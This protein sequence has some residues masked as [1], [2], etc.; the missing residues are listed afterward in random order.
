[1]NKII[2]ERRLDPWTCLEG[3]DPHED[4]RGKENECY[5][6][7][8]DTPDC[9]R[10]E[11]GRIDHR[12]DEPWDGKHPQMRANAEASELFTLRAMVS[13]N[14]GCQQQVRAKEACTHQLHPKERIDPT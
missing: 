11:I 10:S 5:Q 7:P 12:L 3:G 1:M 9:G 2:L 14:I 4:P 8:N 6:K 13:S